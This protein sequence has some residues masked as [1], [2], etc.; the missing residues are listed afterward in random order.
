MKRTSRPD[1]S[2]RISFQQWSSLSGQSRGRGREEL[3]LIPK[4]CLSMRNESVGKWKDAPHKR[5]REREMNDLDLI[6]SDTSIDNE[7]RTPHGHKTSKKGYFSSWNGQNHA[8][9]L[10]S[11]M[12]MEIFIQFIHEIGEKSK[13]FDDCNEN[14]HFHW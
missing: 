3:R 5:G 9:I 7:E 11:S 10:F 1:P 6:L 14:L 12:E 8:W 2:K 13:T 4:R